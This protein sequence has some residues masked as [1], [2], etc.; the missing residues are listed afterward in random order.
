[1]S[2][3]TE[4]VDQLPNN[5]ETGSAELLMSSRIKSLNDEIAKLISLGNVAYRLF[6]VKTLQR[7]RSEQAHFASSQDLECHMN[8]LWR[9]S[10]CTSTSSERE[11]SECVC[12]PILRIISYPYS[13]SLY[14]IL[15]IIISVLRIII[16]H[17][18]YHHPHPHTPYHQSC[19]GAGGVPLPRRTNMLLI[20]SYHLSIINQSIVNLSFKTA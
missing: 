1:M 3:A 10:R 12:Y 15:C 20:H 9:S 19:G 18:P 4:T 14:P 16:S 2:E 8:E 13:I 11:V 5:G 7:L 6:R 17:T